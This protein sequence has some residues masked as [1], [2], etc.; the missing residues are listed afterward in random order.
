M[1]IIDWKNITI[2]C[3]IIQ[4][5]APNNRWKD[6]NVERNEWR[7]LAKAQFKEKM[8]KNLATLR[9]DE[10][11]YKKHLSVSRRLFQILCTEV[12]IVQSLLIQ[13]RRLSTVEQIQDK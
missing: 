8:Q 9:K 12:Q 5:F 1:S 4:Y 6:S 13:Q 11:G 3:S 7:E 2:W 10:K